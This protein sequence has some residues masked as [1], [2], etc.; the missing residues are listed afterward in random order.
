MTTS[1]PET[2]LP[3]S[4]RDKILDVAEA[5]FA[6]RGFEG[7]GMRE[8][9]DAAGLGKSSLFHHFRSKAQLYLAVLERLLAHLDERLREALADPGL[10][11]ARLD[12]WLDAL[13]DALAER[14]PA[15]RLLL[16]GLFEDDAFDAEAWAEGRDAERRIE[17]ILGGILALLRE[18]EEQGAFR[19][20]AGPHTVQTLIGATVYHFASGE[21]GEELLGGPLLSADAVRRRKDELKAFLHHGLAA[22]RPGLPF[23]R[24]SVMQKLMQDH[25][26]RF[27][28][29][30]V[31]E[32]VD[33]A[34]IARLREDRRRRAAQLNW[35]WEYGS[36]VEE[37]RALYE[38]GKVNQWNAEPISTGRSRSRRTSG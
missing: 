7:V 18:G 19:R 33:E 4:S 31:I 25:R 30:E 27:G 28:E 26:K 16:R 38:K 29:F 12:R 21:F 10:P 5:L 23:P 13:V 35:T 36:E 11:L 17:S 3:P 34:E 6:R 15:A 32:F 37:L 22:P 8:V 24:R 2:P 1:P 14:E 9:A 20:T